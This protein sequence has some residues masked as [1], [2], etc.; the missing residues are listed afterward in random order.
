MR[1]WHTAAILFVVMVDR[2][3]KIWAGKALKQVFTLPLWEGVF[4]MTYTENRGA[5]FGL[6]QGQQALFFIITIPM[7]LV[8]LWL[9]YFRM[10]KSKGCGIGLA[11]VL[12]GALGNF[13]DRIVY[14]YVVDMFDF[15]LI[16]FAI[17]NVADMGICIGAAIFLLFYI[18]EDSARARAEK[19][20]EAA[21]PRAE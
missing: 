20:A 6:L 9:L 2:F 19:L 8:L 18:I 13:F 3:V 17:F 15:R 11:L 4:H 1:K 14:G 12:G 21:K 10:P 16:N 5:A 7:T